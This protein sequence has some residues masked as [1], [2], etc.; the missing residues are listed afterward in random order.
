MLVRSEF[1][2]CG[3]ATAIGSLPHTDPQEACSLM[4]SR[5]GRLPVWPQMPKRSFLENMYVQFSEGFPGVVLE[6]DRISVSR[7]QGLDG[8]LEKLY[9]TYLENRVDEWGIAAEYAAGLYAFL[10]A[11]IGSP[12]AIKGQVTG[13]I[14]WGLSVTDENRQP[15]LYD[16]VLGDAIAKHIRLKAAWEERALQAMCPNTIMFVDEPY[17]SAF[18]SAFVSLSR[19][20]VV[21]LL[22]EVF[23]GI[24]G[25]KAIHC[26]GNTDWSLVFST[27]VD[28][29]NFDAFACF[30]GIPLY[31]DHLRSFLDRGGILSWGIVPASGSGD[32]LDPATLL[33][34]LDDRI[35]QLAAK[36]M[37]RDRLYRQAILTPSCGIGSQSVD[38][39]DHVV[40]ALIRLSALVRE[41]ERLEC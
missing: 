40:D 3:L 36:G 23:Q 4:L 37:D 29:V 1:R 19:E 32:N 16:E 18:G 33:Q 25:L 13:P 14:S 30:Q 27:K 22:E 21:S 28:V 15:V 38:D 34:M 2:P 41:R 39:A 24:T 12:V 20:Q 26:C 35:G 6:N 10:S 9:V 7:S 31:P 17:M 5:L 11:E 8:A